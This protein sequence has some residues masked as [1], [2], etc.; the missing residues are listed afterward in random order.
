MTRPEHVI[1]LSRVFWRLVE[2]LEKNDFPTDSATAIVTALF[3][4]FQPIPRSE[5]EE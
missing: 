1:E 2:G 3:R 4:Q 5:L